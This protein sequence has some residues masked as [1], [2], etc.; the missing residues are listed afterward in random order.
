M[1]RRKAISYIA[2]GG[3]GGALAVSGY[4]WYDWNKKPD[5]I[6]IEYHKELIAALAETIIPATDTPGAKDAGVP[7]FMIVLLND[8]TDRKSKNKFIDGLKELRKYC[9]DKHGKEYQHCTEEQQY[10]VLKHFEE[11]GKA[12]PG[13][14]GKVQ[15]KFLGRSFFATL[16]HYTVEGYGTSRLGATKGLVYIPVPGSYHGCIPLQ[17]GQKAW[18]TK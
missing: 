14:L 7:E 18:A 6:F 11:Q 9:L 5:D 1:K 17:P 4:K 15:D 2:L 3:A 8:C 16:K 12:W 10:I 13:L